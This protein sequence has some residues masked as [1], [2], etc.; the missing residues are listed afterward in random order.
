MESNITVY[1]SHTVDINKYPRI[2]TDKEITDK[3]I[4]LFFMNE[5]FLRSLSTSYDNSIQ[6]YHECKEYFYVLKDIHQEKSLKKYSA[7]DIITLIHNMNDFLMGQTDQ[8]KQIEVIQKMNRH[9][10][11]YY[12]YIKNKDFYMNLFEAVKQAKLLYFQ[13]RDYNYRVEPPFDFYGILYKKGATY[14][15]I[16]LMEIYTYTQHLIKRKIIKELPYP[17]YIKK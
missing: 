7:R 14:S 15:S 1:D 8:K 3:I 16:E 5:E 13:R 10:V 17:I 9:D 4:I 2:G 12:F 11:L 6:Y